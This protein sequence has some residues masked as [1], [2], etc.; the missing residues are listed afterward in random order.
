[1]NSPVTVS[2]PKTSRD[3]HSD[4]RSSEHPIRERKDLRFGDG[5][6]G[7]RQTASTATR[8]VKRKS[9]LFACTAP[10]KP[11]AA[12]M[13]PRYARCITPPADQTNRCATESAGS[14]LGLRRRGRSS[15][16]PLAY[17]PS[18]RCMRL[19]PAIRSPAH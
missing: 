8:A 12:R 19:I 18:G 15:Q 5:L 13:G 9:M 7:R 17:M 6:D 11:L 14:D 10:V 1:M 2:G 16:G 4:S 3:V